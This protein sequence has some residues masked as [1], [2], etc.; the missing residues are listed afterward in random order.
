MLELFDSH[1][2]KT[3][4][5]IGS[6]FLS[7]AEPGYQK[8]GEVP[9]PQPGLWGYQCLAEC[10]DILLTSCIGDGCWL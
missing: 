8:F 5:L 1:F 6:N 10:G 4:D 9:P 7:R 3:L 2:Y